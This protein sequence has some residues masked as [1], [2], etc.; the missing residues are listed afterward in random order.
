MWIETK[1]Y[2]ETLLISYFWHFNKNDSSYSFLNLHKNEKL[3]ESQWEFLVFP[4]PTKKKNCLEKVCLI[5]RL[6]NFMNIFQDT[7]LLENCFG[8]KD[9]LLI[10]SMHKDWYKQGFA[11]YHLKA[12]PSYS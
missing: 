3:F 2:L 10:F 8:V 12:T 1:I 7:F 11:K 9:Q 5:H 6:N 4:T